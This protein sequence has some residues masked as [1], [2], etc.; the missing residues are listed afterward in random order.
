M[1][2]ADTLFDI[3][4]GVGKLQNPFDF[5]TIIHILRPGYFV[6]MV[7]RSKGS[8]QCGYGPITTLYCIKICIKDARVYHRRFRFKLKAIWG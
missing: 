6:R 8:K 7:G 1:H 3:K 4:W 2:I 5:S